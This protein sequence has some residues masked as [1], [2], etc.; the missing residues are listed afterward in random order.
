LDIAA[1][2]GPRKLDAWLSARRRIAA[3]FVVGVCLGGVVGVFAAWQVSV[4]SAWCGAAGAFVGLAW[5]T[6]RGADGERTRALAMRDDE[7]RVVADVV[8]LVACT[9]SL[10]GVGLLLLEASSAKGVA[11][12]GMTALGV[13]SVV[14]A[15]GMVHTVFTLRYADLYYS[16]DGGIDFNSAEEPDYRDFAYLAFTIGMTYQVS[17]TNIATKVLRRTALKHALLSYVFGTAII[18]VTISTVAGLVRP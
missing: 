8:V 5:A 12:A 7:T 6:M 16:R 10:V 3:G 2:V 14:L 17:D 11:L 13:L 1:P 9:A 4:L 18:A 15:W